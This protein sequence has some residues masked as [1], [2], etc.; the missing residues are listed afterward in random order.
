MIVQVPILLGMSS[1]LEQLLIRKHVGSQFIKRGRAIL[2]FAVCAVA[3][4]FYHVLLVLYP[5]PTRARVI[6]L[7]KNIISIMMCSVLLGL[8]Y[9]SLINCCYNVKY[10]DRV[11]SST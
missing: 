11:I 10:V 2:N 5:P 1:W 6:N 3:R 8:F 4:S 9:I 7:L